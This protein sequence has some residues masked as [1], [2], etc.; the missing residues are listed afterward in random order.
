MVSLFKH[1]LLL[2]PGQQSNTVHGIL[3]DD[4]SSNIC[5]ILILVR[6]MPHKAKQNS[7]NEPKYNLHYNTYRKE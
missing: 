5:N 4:Q 1:L 7:H 3:T 6:Q 2:L